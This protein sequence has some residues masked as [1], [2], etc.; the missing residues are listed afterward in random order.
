MRGSDYLQVW[1]K[2]LFLQELLP[3]S[4]STPQLL[5]NSP[6][7][8]GKNWIY[9][10]VSL[11]SKWA[12]L[13][14]SLLLNLQQLIPFAVALYYFN[15][16]SLCLPPEREFGCL[17]TIS[18]MTATKGF[19]FPPLSCGLW[20]LLS[21]GGS[22]FSSCDLYVISIGSKFSISKVWFFPIKWTAHTWAT[23]HDLISGLSLFWLAVLPIT[24][25]IKFPSFL[26]FS[27]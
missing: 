1:C 14:N 2:A 27:G 12:Y 24:I 8:I 19:C 3:A 18:A 22:P 25:D 15:I 23:L 16:E 17:H 21:A 4:I 10:I 20:V 6:S 5:F 11:I 7:F 26:F 13:I 9:I